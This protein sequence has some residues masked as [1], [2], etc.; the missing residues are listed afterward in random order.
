[1]VGA[2]LGAGGDAAAAY[3]LQGANDSRF[4]KG[5]AAAAQRGVAFAGAKNVGADR[6]AF[7]HK[8][9]TT[10]ITPPATRCAAWRLIIARPIRKRRGEEP[11]ARA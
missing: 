7:V 10:R 9:R 5:A 6:N 11:G 2:G 8:G 4:A 1:M 3:G